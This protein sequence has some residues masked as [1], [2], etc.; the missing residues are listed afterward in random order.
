[1]E[2]DFT[3]YHTTARGAQYLVD[4]FTN[5]KENGDIEKADEKTTV[6]EFDNL[7]GTETKPAVCHLLLA[8]V[9]ASGDGQRSDFKEWGSFKNIDYNFSWTYRK[10]IT[11][12]ATKEALQYCH[13]GR[14]DLC[15]ECNPLFGTTVKDLIK[16]YRNGETI[17]KH[18]YVDETAY[19]TKEI[20]QEFVNS[21]EY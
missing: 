9:F 3:N 11:F 16:K 6:I 2:V 18:V 13:D 21:R 7:D 12:D 10:I 20:T 19:T 17:P 15:V 8:H 4:F 14:I 1:M 5:K